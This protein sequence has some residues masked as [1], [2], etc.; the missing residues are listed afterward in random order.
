VKEPE[1]RD[2]LERKSISSQ[3]LCGVRF[4]KVRGKILVEEALTTTVE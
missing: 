3:K 4:H 2:M 1:K